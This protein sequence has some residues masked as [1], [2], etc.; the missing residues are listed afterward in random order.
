MIGDSL[1]VG[2]GPYLRQELRGVAPLT[3][4]ARN[5]RPSPEGVEGLRSRPAPGHSWFVLLIR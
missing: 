4:D 1:E 2:T 3:V 5:G